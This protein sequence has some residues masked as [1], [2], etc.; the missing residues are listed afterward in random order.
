MPVQSFLKSAA[1]VT[2]SP[3]QLD[4][5]D[6]EFYAFIHFT[7]NTYTDMEWGLGTEDPALFNPY[8]RSPDHRG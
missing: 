6:T 2:P 7:V 4:W 1:S 3:R 8:D 5:F